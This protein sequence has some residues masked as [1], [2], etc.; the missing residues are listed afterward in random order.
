LSAKDLV[1]NH[2]SGSGVAA[3]ITKGGA[4]E[5]LTVNKTSGSG[6]AMS[7]TGG[8]TQLSELHL[9]T[10]LADAYIA[11]AATWNA[12]FNLPALTSGSVLF[13]NGTT[14][15]QDNSNLFW[16]DTNNRLGIGTNAPTSILHLVGQ[17]SSVSVFTQSYYVNTQGNAPG[18]TLQ[19][20]RGTISS[21]TSLLSDDVIAGF[22]ASGYHSGGAFGANTTAFRFVASQNFTSTAQGTRIE[23]FTTPNGSTTRAERLRITDAGNLLINTTTDAGFRL[24]VNGSVRATGSISAASAIARGT[25]LNQT[26]VATANGDTLVGLDIAPNFTNGAFTGLRNWALR[27]PNASQIGCGA[28]TTYSFYLAQNETTINAPSG[29]VGVQIAA[30]NVARF[31]ASTGNLTLQSGGTFTDIASARLAVNSTTQGFLPPRMTSAQ[32]TAIASPATG[33]IV[34]Q[35]DGVEGLYVKKAAAWAMVSLV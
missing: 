4:G 35:T 23:F 17:D 9:T 33:L 24:D 25:F 21:P 5:A 1:I 27:L 16:D 29:F 3:S 8:V 2:S 28:S 30:G 7:V 10:D 22:F 11:S 34:Y 12:K 26:L 19:R 6:N 15:A 20:A 32:R 14:I 31:F 18:F 13:S